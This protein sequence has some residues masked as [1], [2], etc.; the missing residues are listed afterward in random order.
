[1]GESNLLI[2]EKDEYV[3]VTINRP[4]KLN[5]LNSD[6]ISELNDTL[7][8]IENSS[9]LK[10]VIITGEGD[11]AFAAGADITELTELNQDQAASFSK[12]GSSVFLRIEKM[13]KPV[14]AAVNGFAL[15]G[16]CELVMA[17]HLRIASSNARFGLPEINLGIIPGYGGTQ[18][19]PRLVGK[20]N[21]LYY[22]LSGEMMDASTALGFGLI[23]EMVEPQNLFI[24]AEEI[25][26]LLAQ[27]APIA[28]KY[29]L[30][31]IT[32]GTNTSLEN[33]LGIETELF[34][35]VCSTED[36]REG[37]TA[38]IE[39]RKPKFKGE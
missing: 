23:N 31:A 17:C 15:G 39:K 4:E 20:T 6:T 10:S 29:V 5:A 7:Q 2:K 38:F 3:I 22:I 16:G 19:L 32:K 26:S 27:K 28:V 35:E 18:R 11:K 37:T 8:K 34:G 25:A 1:M 36:M 14:I 12:H 33:G 9:H 21:A 30:Q 13:S 24:R